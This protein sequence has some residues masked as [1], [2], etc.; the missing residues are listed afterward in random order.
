MTSAGG[1]VLGVTEPDLALR[2]SLPGAAG[3]TEGS[4]RVTRQH[5]RGQAS[6]VPP[7]FPPVPGQ[8][9]VCGH[10]CRV[11]APFLLS[12]K[13]NSTVHR[14]G[15]AA[16]S[17]KKPGAQKPVRA[18]VFGFSFLIVSWFYSSTAKCSNA[19]PS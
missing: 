10:T 7:A 5:R 16:T 4:Y 12:Q 9:L 3:H 6:R 1:A 13:S 17:S 18:V 8:L 19:M 14:I 15:C 2:K 11:C